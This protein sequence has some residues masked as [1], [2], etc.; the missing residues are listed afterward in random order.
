MKLGRG[1]GTLLLGRAR[2]QPCRKDLITL[3]GSALDIAS[4][5]CYETPTLP[6][7]AR[8]L[9]QQSLGFARDDNNI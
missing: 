4:I 3:K 7:S 9:S 1:V 8:K 6:Q 5:T 2:L